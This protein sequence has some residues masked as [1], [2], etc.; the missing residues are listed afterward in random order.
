MCDPDS[1]RNV[2]V[3]KKNMIFLQSYDNEISHRALADSRTYEVVGKVESVKTKQNYKNITAYVTFEHE[4]AAALAGKL[5]RAR[6]LVSMA[7]VD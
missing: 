3:L 4:S 7:T 6:K 1:L 2:R 5:E